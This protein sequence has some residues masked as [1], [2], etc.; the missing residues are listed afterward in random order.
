MGFPQCTIGHIS[1]CPADAH[2]CPGC[3]HPVQGPA[4]SGA[5]T[6]HV[7]GKPAVRVGDKGSHTACCGPN[8]WTASKGSTTVIILGAKAHRKVPSD[9]DT[10]CGGIGFMTEGWDDVEVGGPSG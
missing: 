8:T 2:G 7:H 9:I 5:K 6:V 4:T 3:P 1:K 10:H